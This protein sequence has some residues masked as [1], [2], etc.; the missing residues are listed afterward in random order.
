MITFQVL[1]W[2][3]IPAQIKVQEPGKRPISKPLP[4]RFQQEIDRVAMK[5]GLSG[6]DAYLEQWQWSAKQPREGT[7]EEIAESVIAELIQAFDSPK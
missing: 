5:E 6:T 2:K 7:V 4:D 3:H 1:Y